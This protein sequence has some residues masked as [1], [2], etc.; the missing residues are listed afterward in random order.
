M[1][2]ALIEEA[3]DHPEEISVSFTGQQWL[4]RS[5]L[6]MIVYTDFGA[7]LL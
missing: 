6:K 4:L 1:A 3:E 7:L 5:F 2:T